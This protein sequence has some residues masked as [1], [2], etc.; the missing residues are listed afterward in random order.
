MNFKIK[1]LPFLALFVWLITLPL[2]SFA[3][4]GLIMVVGD[5]LPLKNQVVWRN[6]VR[7]SERREGEHL[8][9]AAVHDRPK[10]YGGFTL[11]AYQQY[12]KVAD[13][14]PLAEEFQEF[15]TDQRYLKEDET[16]AERIQGASFGTLAPVPD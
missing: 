1:M 5:V 9:I 11:R 7:L 15:S 4:D 16:T 13:L 3:V 6:L 12:G 10:L 2:P 8:V 14:I